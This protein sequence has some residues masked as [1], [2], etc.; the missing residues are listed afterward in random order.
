MYTRCGDE[1]MNDQKDSG[2]RG[3]YLRNE[4]QFS[5]GDGVRP[6]EPG[7]VLTDED[8][9]RRPRASPIG[10][11]P[12]R[13]QPDSRMTVCGGGG[14]ENE[15]GA[16]VNENA[17]LLPSPVI[18]RMNLNMAERKVGIWKAWMIATTEAER[19]QDKNKVLG[20]QD[21]KLKLGVGQAPT[22]WAK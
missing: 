14:G 3:R 21:T 17:A 11:L 8:E 6:F 2:K 13:S 15:G 10:A 18:E 4:S 22:V 9:Q 7:K 19:P 20:R 12:I 1:Q 16:A 5:L